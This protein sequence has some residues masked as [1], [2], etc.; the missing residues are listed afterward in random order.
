MSIRTV[1]NK[2]G[3]IIRVRI[4][5]PSNTVHS[6][7]AYITFIISSIVQSIDLQM[8]RKCV[9]MCVCA[10]MRMYVHMCEC[11]RACMRA[12]MYISVCACIHVCK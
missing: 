9:S 6:K 11:V 7:I 12:C 1:S 10:C 8:W 2:S 5:N 4:E 3:T